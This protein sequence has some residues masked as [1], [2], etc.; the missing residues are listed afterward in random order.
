MA[1]RIPQ[2][3]IDE[4]IARVDIVEVIDERVPL[5]KAGR[6]HVACCPFHTEKTPSFSVSPSKQFYY[7]FGCGAHGTALGF[8]MDYAHL[9]F[10]DAV[11]E[12]ADRTGMVVPREG[13]G[14][15]GSQSETAELHEILREASVFYRRQL[16]EHPQGETAVRYLQTRGMSGEIAAQ[17]HLGYAPPGWDNLVRTLGG[18]QRTAR[19]LTKSG[20]AIDKG[21]ERLYDRFRNRVVFPIRDRRGR[22][23]AFGAR[24]LGDETPKYLNSPET[25]V[26]HKGRELYGLFEA[27]GANRS[28]RRLFVVEGY[29]DVVSLAHAGISNA[30]A[31]LGT[32]ATA[33]QMTRAFRTT[34]EVV[35]CFDGDE[36]GRRAAW[37]AAQTLLPLLRDGWLASFMFLPEG[38][39]PDTVVRAR[40]AEGFNAEA[41]RAVSLSDFLFQHLGEQENLDTL[42]G[43]AR[44][45]ELARPLLGKLNA[46]AF[47]N[48][49][50]ARLSEITGL[51]APELARLVVEEDRAP[52]PRAPRR[53]PQRR[54]NPSLIRKVITLLLYRPDLAS[55]IEGTGRLAS[56]EVPGAVLLTELLDFARSNPSVT[57]GATV[58]HFRSHP[59]GRHLAKLAGETSPT[60]A[61]GLEREFTDAIKRL[62]EMVDSQRF[63]ELTRKARAG[64]LTHEE[65]REFRR[66]LEPA[67]ASPSPPSGASSPGRQ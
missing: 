4:L 1:N 7:C 31:T 46:R 39:D 55:L 57:L 9:E 67:A 38:E 63:D 58:E 8:L 64:G 49:A 35:F 40:G 52:R 26:F 25:P 29:M 2:S 20:L 50:I 44:L 27:R 33:D 5:K 60:L 18:S 28:L 17:F 32:A 34:A 62:E 13:G 14:D 47:Q 15:L 54:G 42:D 21:G 22:V 10:L 59:E 66:L 56:L 11:Q 12:L 61:E 36:A 41:E 43:R 51:S 23:V 65:E 37:R 16:R 53:A 45:I 3:F 48:L 6:D 19:L 24:A 30:V